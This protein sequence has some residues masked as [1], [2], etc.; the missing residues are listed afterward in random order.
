MA[1]TDH[2][3]DTSLLAAADPAVAAAPPRRASHPLEL[4]RDAMAAMGQAVLRRAI[5]FVE[6]LPDRPAAS[7]GDAPPEL[8]RAMLAPPPEGPGELE[9]LLDRLDQASSY[10]YEAGSPG[11]YAYIPGGGLFT[12]AVADLYSGAT[13]RYVG[14]AFAAPAMV[15]LEQGMV[16]WLAGICGLPEGS[17]GLLLT[18]GSMATLCAVIAARHAGL[19]D[20]LAGGTLYASAE[21][22]H[23]VAKAARLAGLA[24]EAVRIVPCD[25][26][27]GLDP[28]A[29]AGMI[30]D[31]RA[32]GKRPFLVVGTAGTTNTGA[33]DPLPEM[34]AIA[35]RE[36]LWFHIDGAY[37]GMF[38]LTRRGQ[39]RLRG[40][41][42]A[43]SITL[44]QHKTMFLPFGASTLVVREPHRLA[45]AYQADAAY[46]AGMDGGRGLPDF[47]D[48]GPELTRGMRGLR[49]WLPLHLHGVG[50]FRDALDEKLDLAQFAYR[51]LLDEPA[52]ELPWQP[53][54]SIVAFRMR[55]DGPGPEAARR[56]DQASQALLDRINAGG[57]VRLSGT[58][59][60]GR[61]TLRLCIVVHRA[62]A[63]RVAEAIRIIRAAVRAVQPLLTP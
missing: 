26:A 45:A 1:D 6:S 39:T 51:Q 34:A 13:N 43:D 63:D 25:A 57:R 9:P 55:P 4:G 56:A 58:T 19:G 35:R 24:A 15:A 14:H 12:S 49:M 10:A 41:E 11:F 37:G 2:P 61:V 5:A 32:A 53:P 31:D 3:C 47:S 20:D 17:G 52:L 50:A 16:R 22:H 46:L 18:G 36:G 54:L 60:G 8:I 7:A 28:D 30:A 59:V 44:D 40:M 33:I 21:T 48:L 42:Q 23:S 62:H 38:R 27:L 29:L